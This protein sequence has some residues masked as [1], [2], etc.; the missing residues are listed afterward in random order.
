MFTAD[1]H[2]H[3]CNITMSGIDSAERACSCEILLYYGNEKENMCSLLR[4][5]PQQNLQLIIPG[6]SRRHVAVIT[7]SVTKRNVFLMNLKI[8]LA[9]HI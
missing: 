2:A 7:V 4:H 6:V 5:N 9:A 8:V 3:Q 1:T